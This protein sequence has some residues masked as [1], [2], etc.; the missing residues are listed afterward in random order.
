MKTFIINKNDS[1][2]RLDSFLIKTVPLLPKS[3]MHKYIR[4]KKIKLNGKRSSHNVKLYEGDVLELYIKDE[5][6]T[7][8]NNKYDFL[9]SSGH[10]DIVYEDKNI[11]LINKPLG[12]LSHSDKKE[13]FD[14][15]VTRILR[16]LYEKGEYDPKK[17]NSFSPALANRIDR[18]TTGI[19]IAAK[20][21]ETLRALNELIKNKEIRRFYLCVCIGKFK[22]NSGLLTGFLKKDENTNTVIITDKRLSGSKRAETAYKVMHY[23]NGLSL[24]EA[25]LITGRPH[26]LRAHFASI[27]HPILGDV[28]YIKNKYDELHK[29]YK[30]QLLCSYKISFEL[31]TDKSI[32]NYLN[33]KTFELRDI[34]FK[35]KFNSL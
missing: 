11:I 33:G 2:K 30:S 19:V 22:E 26:Q 35:R 27:N 3:L 5:F 24:I 20:N 8:D 13:R 34:W 12:L 16:Y 10:L 21:A 15:A 14:T 18:N 1:E 29:R 31:K 23:N 28:K 17:E 32:L 9:K 6:F 25:E 4:E 7:R